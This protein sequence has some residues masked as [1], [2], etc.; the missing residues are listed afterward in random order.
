MNRPGTTP[1]GGPPLVAV[2][3]ASGL[4]GSAVTARLARLPVAVRAVSRRPAATGTAE[5]GTGGAGGVEVLAADLTVPA[6]LERAVAGASAVIHLVLHSGGW[7]GAD[8]DPAA[9]E[10]VNVGVMRDLVGLLRSRPRSGPAPLVV[11]AGSASQAGPGSGT[12]I[13]GTVPDHPVTAYDLQKQAAEDLLKRATSEG[14][15]RGVSLRLPTVFGPAPCGAADRGVVS[16]MAR[17][18]LAGEPLTMWHDGTIARE[19]LY[20]G[21]VA[22]AFLAA[23]DRPE[24]LAGRHWP[25][26]HGRGEPLGDVFRRIALLV[27]ERTGRPPVPV[28]PVPPPA[29]AR[30]GDFDSVVIDSSAFR[31][32]TGWRP[33]VPLDEA[34]RRTVAALDTHA[35][36]TP[37]LDTCGTRPRES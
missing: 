22:D 2:L 16:A 3:G 37:A 9:S 35:L 25:L 21:D 15:L 34:L 29:S 19:L 5:S 18:A 8:E 4:V 31:A 33:R 27:A 6:N 23:L 1:G 10:R 17:R 32:A 11:F 7:R 28:V 14:V 20:V 13:D 24:A 36:G 26:G 30:P 12:P